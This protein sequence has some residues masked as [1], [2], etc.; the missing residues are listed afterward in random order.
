M[1]RTIELDAVIVRPRLNVTIDKAKDFVVS[2]QAGQPIPGPEGPM[3]PPGPQGIP[4]PTGPK[5][6][7]GDTGATGAQGPIGLPG[8]TGATGAQGDPGTPGATGPQGPQ[9]EIGFPGAQGPK[10]DTGD[11]GT[12]GTP[13]APGPQ[14]PKGDQGSTGVTG[15][16]GIQ[17]PQGTPG[18][19]ANILDEG[20]SL[21]SR[22]SLDFV[23]AGVTATD[24]SALGR[25]VITIPGASGGHIIQEEGT[26]LTARAALNFIGVGV[27]ATDDA[28]NSRT[29]VTITGSGQTPWLQDIHGGNFNLGNVKAI[30]V[31]ANANP[32]IAGVYV[33]T[34]GAGVAGFRHFDS[35]TTGAGSIIVGNDLGHLGGL[36]FGGSLLATTG[37]RDVLSFYT[38]SATP[39]IFATQEVERMR[40]KEDGKVGINCTPFSEQLEVRGDVR[41][42]GPASST[43]LFID[44]TGAAGSTAIYFQAAGA[45][46]GNI[47]AGSTSVAVASNTYLSLQ[48]GSTPAERVRIT[49]AGLM[50]IGKTPATYRLEVSGDIDITGVYRING[51]AIGSGAVSSVFTRTGAVVA[52]S[53]DYTAAQV[54]NAVSTLGSYADPAWITSLAYAKITGAPAAT[55]QTPWLQDIHGNSKILY[56]VAAIGIQVASPQVALQVA[57]QIWS[58]ADTVILEYAAH[59]SGY[60][61]VGC[62]SFHPLT[63]WT[64]QLERMRILADGKVGIGT[65]NPLNLLQVHAATDQNLGIRHDGAKM[66][67]GTYN[68]AGTL[69]V[70]MNFNASS[71][72]F[73]TGSVG[74]GTGNL[75]TAKLV[76]QA[77]IDRVLVVRGDPAP[78]GFPAGM[79]GPILAGV[80]SDHSTFEPFTIAGS[81]INL[82]TGNVG[83][84]TTAPAHRLDV[85][86]NCNVTGQYLV[87][88][89]PLSTGGSQTPWTQNIAGGGFNLT[90][91]SLIQV[92]NVAGSSY[93][94]FHSSSVD[95][96]YIGVGPGDGTEYF[97]I[98]NASGIV[99]FRA[100]SNGFVGIGNGG[101]PTHTLRLRVGSDQNILL[102]TVGTPSLQSI[103]D[104]YSAY[105]G[106]NYYASAHIFNGIVGACAATNPASYTGAGLV[107]INGSPS[108]TEGAYQLQIGESTQNPAYRLQI[109]YANTAGAWYGVIQS[110]AGNAGAPLFL[111][112]AGG[113][114]AVGTAQTPFSK[115]SM[116]SVGANY[117]QQRIAFY[118]AADGSNMY[119]IG[120]SNAA[121]ASVAIWAGQIPSASV[122][123]TIFCYNGNIGVGVGAA[124][125]QARVSTGAGLATVK[126][127]THDDGINCFGIGVQSS[128]LTFAASTN[129]ATGNAHMTLASNGNL[130]IGI[131]NAGSAH[132]LTVNPAAVVNTFA[133]ASQQVKIGEPSNVAG[134]GM[135][136][137]YGIPSARYGGTIQ[138]WDNG[139][140]GTLY[141]NPSGGNI[142]MANSAAWGADT[143]NMPLGTMMIYY[144]HSNSYLYF[145]IKRTDTQVIR[146]AAFLCS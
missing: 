6:D 89:V 59:S 106:M 95:K 140:V 64:N 10:G 27:T 84:N 2:L 35:A 54:T 142:V 120:M 78:F 125:P 135:T 114:L 24:D 117:D 3:G 13:G 105:I 55:G 97:N 21:T 99:A 139:A 111:N 14:G 29:N 61:R 1:T 81:S 68:D 137:G 143:A 46:R 17:G 129:A 67:I 51:V 110:F 53:G 104:A 113:S 96:W 8:A 116:G 72:E 132:R 34:A 121:S 74:I 70:P 43:F 52:V 76:V 133:L 26:P 62:M 42:K 39:I 47:T 127:A 75:S 33:Q 92:N 112:P 73:V 30:G 108:G 23:G 123:H 12:P 31:G 9:G 5:G 103:N 65:T 16:P 134:Y 86:G 88:G 36:I 115:I 25:T 18:N 49:A 87:N 22:T 58:V 100:A 119:G 20:I 48:T 60:G 57:G 38:Q 122:N 71:F 124:I 41:F 32:V 94:N 19:S 128:V 146:S 118:E 83:I 40:V 82:M 98:F 102:H 101:N 136:L 130:G 7:T 90:N 44:T 126:F 93:I 50:G 28:A 63:L 138:A 79:L 144:N 141:L 69:G 56:S 37:L 145:Y 66:G 4:G 15:P 45:A 77:A 85:V 107:L 131:G 91:V 109:G 80:S 11:P